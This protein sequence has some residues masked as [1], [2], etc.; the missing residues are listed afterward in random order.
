MKYIVEEIDHEED[1]KKEIH[2]RS[3]NYEDES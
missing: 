3:L 1:I 2:N